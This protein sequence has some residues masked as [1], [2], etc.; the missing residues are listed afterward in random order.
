[1]NLKNKSSIDRSSILLTSLE[2]MCCV[3]CFHSYSSLDHMLYSRI[4]YRT[5]S[6]FKDGTV[7]YPSACC[8]FH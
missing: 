4:V 7:L 1:M 3:L 8:V 2:K 6:T 5:A